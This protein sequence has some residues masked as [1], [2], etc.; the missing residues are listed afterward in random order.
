MLIGWVYAGYWRRLQLRDKF[1]L[2][3]HVCTKVGWHWHYDN[4]KVWFLLPLINLYLESDGQGVVWN[5]WQLRTQISDSLD[6][7]APLLIIFRVLEF[8]GFKV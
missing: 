7:E 8:L 5:P 4:I 1:C 6:D 3:G 2:L